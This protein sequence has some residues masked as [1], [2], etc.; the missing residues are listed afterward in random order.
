MLASF[1][2]GVENFVGD[3]V[4]LTDGL[5]GV[6]GFQVR[7]NGCPFRRILFCGDGGKGVGVVIL[8][9]VL[10]LDG[11]GTCGALGQLGKKHCV[12]FVGEGIASGF[13]DGAGIEVA[14]RD[15][16]IDAI[17]VGHDQQ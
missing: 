1:S 6:E 2:F 7:L 5:H 16:V 11:D 15:V 12:G 13:D 8:Y 9:V 4:H 10:E 3:G 17:V 14:V